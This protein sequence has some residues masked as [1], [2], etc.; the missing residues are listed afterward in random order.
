MRSKIDEPG[1]TTASETTVVTAGLA[2]TNVVSLT[3]PQPV[4]V[5]AWASVAAIDSW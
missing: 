1:C 3:S 4:T 2:C 5:P